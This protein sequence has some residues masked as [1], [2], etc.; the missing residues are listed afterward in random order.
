MESNA[1]SD[2]GLAAR[3]SRRAFIGAGLRLSAGAAAIAALNKKWVGQSTAIAAQPQ[4]VKVLIQDVSDGSPAT[5]A[6]GLGRGGATAQGGSVHLPA[7]GSEFVSGAVQLLFGATHLGLHWITPGASPAGLTVAVRTS[8]APGGWGAW[9]QVTVE[10][11]GGDEV[12]AA[13]VSGQGGRVAQYK[14]TNTSDEPIELTRMTL[15]AINSEDGPLMTASAAEPSAVTL[16]VADGTSITVTTRAG[17][18]CDETLR[19][20][21]STERWPEMY[22]PAKKVVLHHTATANNYVNGAAEVRAIYAYHAQTLGWGDIGYHLLVDKN[23]VIYEGRHGRGED[24]SREIASAD[25]VAGHV[26]GFN[27]GSTGVAA[28]GNSSQGNWRNTWGS[29]GSRG[30]K[31]LE[32]AVTFECGR[33]F[34]D[35]QGNSDFLKADGTWELALD[36]CP[37][38]GDMVATQCPGSTLIKYLPNLRSNV[39]TRLNGSLPPALSGELANADSLNFSWP[40]GSYF[41]SLE[42]WRRLFPGEDIEYL[43]GFTSGEWNDPL[44][45]KQVWTQTTGTAKSFSGLA[46]GHYTMH[47]RR[48]ESGSA[49]RYASRLSFW[50]SESSG[51]EPPPADEAPTV[52][53]KQPSD[54]TTVSGTVTLLADAGDDYGV[55]SVE[56][57][58]DGVRI[59]TGVNGGTGWAL[60]WDSAS[61]SD[62]SHTLGAV[63]TDTVGQTAADEISVSVENAAAPTSGMHVGDLDGVSV[64]QGSTWIA[65]VR[66]TIHDASHGPVN[67]VTVTGSWNGGAS[68]TVSQ[69]TGVDGTCVLQSPAIPKKTSNVTFA[70]TGISHPELTYSDSANHDM[71][72]N[73]NG[74]TIVVPK[75]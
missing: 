53:L 66:I 26:V 44:A 32:D 23:G 41:Y 60:K 62:G 63:A 46:N 72:G 36:H 49:G 9:Q 29:A 68:G 16:S 14:V 21:G 33:H 69:G 73:S 7:G 59:G 5:F 50:I 56:F 55:N 70:V 1:R 37:G 61:V 58:V 30:L 54:G 17:W 6:R 20:S 75:P 42:G 52:T 39:A 48:S 25:V 27:Y 31:A 3:G 57:Y 19:F 38:H 15:T 2:S 65:S 71:D 74:T 4:R 28:I 12:F 10:A 11:E 24:D 45:R 22:V 18:G 13:L 8:G 64:N 35:P 51:E 40:S 34:I 67:G 43:S 47:L